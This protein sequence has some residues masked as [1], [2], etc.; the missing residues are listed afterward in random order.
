MRRTLFLIFLTVLLGAV[1]VPL[2]G[3]D[4][5]SALNVITVTTTADD[6]TS[7]SGSLRD[8]FAIASSDGDASEIVLA[9]G[10]TYPL[11]CDGGGAL[12]HTENSSL[13]IT[14]NGAT[15]ARQGGSCTV[16]VISNG[17]GPLVARGVTVH[18][19][20]TNGDDGAGIGSVGPVTLEDSTMMANLAFNGNAG[21]IHS[22]GSV[23]LTRS[24]IKENAT[25]QN[26]GAITSDTGVV[27][28]DST[29]TGNFVA[30]NGSG[31]GGAVLS[32]GP[33]TVD[34]STFANNR[35]AGTGTGGA[36]DAVGPVTV[37]DSTFTANRADGGGGGAIAANGVV[38][39][40]N[41]SFESNGSDGGSDGGGAIYGAD[42]VDV[43]GSQFIANSASKTPR[44]GGAIH[45]VGTI[46]AT[47]STFE[48][49]DALANSASA[50]GGAL[51]ATVAVDVTGSTLVRNR[52]GGAVGGAI[53]S[54][55]SVSLTGSTVHRNSANLGAFAGIRAGTDATVTDSVLTENTV[56]TTG[57]GGA[58]AADGTATVVNSTIA[59]NVAR[60][61]A[62]VH[63]LTAD[64]TNSTIVGNSGNGIHGGAITL[65]HV[66]L[67][68]N[69]SNDFGTNVNANSLA[70]FAS[71]LARPAGG[72]PSCTVNT[73][74][75]NGYNYDDDSCG[76]TDPTDLG[77]P[78]ITPALG[79]LGANGGP[80][81]TMLPLEGDAVGAG[82]APVVDAIPPE[83]CNT[84][85][86]T[87]QRGASR[88]INTNCDIGAVEHD[89]R[90]D[91]LVRKATDGSPFAGEGAYNN[92][93]S[94]QSVTVTK[95]KKKTAKFVI[96]AENDSPLLAEELLVTG[97]AGNT[98]FKV[99]YLDGATDVTAAVT[100]AGYVVT[101]ALAPG[102][103]RDLSLQVKITKKASPGEEFPMLITIAS[104]MSER[105]DTVRA[106]PKRK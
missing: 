74:T 101:P 2:I 36:I 39:V 53:N 32:V 18:G 71:I 63:A 45:S 6:L 68:D 99:K 17:A 3:A 29:I 76:L 37:T 91:G 44:G 95:A 84:A 20:L 13:T 14:G 34:G 60:L 38:D 79:A 78:I 77:D 40:T 83:D 24:T 104:D 89:A 94:G 52:V 80:T 49:N 7:G 61:G 1:G 9:A 51:L 96:R 85:V 102:A 31:S 100:A 27:I 87:D 64:V 70:S 16:R 62:G 103:E 56:N 72:S 73:P 33:V 67:A 88:P 10:A 26:G 93:G 54:E 105:V 23:T 42:D 82:E 8:A 47:G 15:L 4:P 46:T 98:D 69:L 35:S 55:G 12:A 50:G 21:A 65:H 41:T 59:G 97:P 106:V 19:G 92:D 81:P 28:T 43:D 48:S 30:Q 5:A 75:S 22:D 57:T 25:N 90:P 66:T 58:V 86:D 11:T